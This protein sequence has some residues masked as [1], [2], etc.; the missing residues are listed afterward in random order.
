MDLWRHLGY[1]NPDKFKHQVHVVG[2]GAIGSHVVDTL[3]NLGIENIVV[4]DFD[5]VEGHNLPNQV[6]RPDQIGKP[7]VTALLEHIRDKTGLEIQA[8]VERVENIR[9]SVSGYLF[10]CT[11]SMESR[12]AIV[13][14][15]ARLNDNVEYVV[16]IRMGIAQGRVYVFDPRNKDHLQKWFDPDGAGYGDENS[17]ESPCN[18]KSIVTT[19][20][21]LSAFAS[22]ML[23]FSHQED[24]QQV[25][26]KD[27]PL[28]CGEYLISMDGTVVKTHW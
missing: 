28:I 18:A 26:L 11:D 20:K 13:R 5:D 15:S 17:E 2:A 7:K 24:T 3:A 8:K 16:D 1:F 25:P 4:Y 19:A 27:L 12:K 9:D 21:L 14:G 22:H 10:L 6:Y 23:I